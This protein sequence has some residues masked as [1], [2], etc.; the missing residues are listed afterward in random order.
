MGRIE[1]WTR[2]LRDDLPGFFKGEILFDDIARLLYSTDAS[3]FQIKPAGVVVP[4]DEEDVCGLVRYAQEQ[5]IAL[6]PRG[7]GTGLAGQAPGPGLIVDFSRH[8]RDIVEINDDSVPPS[9][10]ASPMPA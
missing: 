1:P 2:R 7:A 10:R 6:V 3:I 4:R 8:L 5:G 9:S